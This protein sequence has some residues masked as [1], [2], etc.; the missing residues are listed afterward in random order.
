ME[1]GILVNVDKVVEQLYS[2]DGKSKE[3]IMNLLDIKRQD[4]NEII[5]R[6]NLQKPQVKLTPSNQKFVN[7]HREQIVSMLRKDISLKNIAKELNITSDK[8]WYLVR[9]TPDLA[10]ERDAQKERIHNAFIAREMNKSSLDYDNRS[11][12]G[13]E[14]KPILGYDTYYISNCGRVKHYVKA[15]DAYNVMSQ[16]KNVRTGR[17][18]VSLPDNNGKMHNLIVARLVAHAFCNGY[19]EKYNTV[20]H[21]DGDVTN[22]IAENLEWVSQGE[23]NKH[24]YDVLNRTRNVGHPLLYRINYQ[25]RYIFKTVAAFAR[26]I[27]KSEITARRWLE[28]PAKHDI[29]LL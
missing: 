15:Y 1:S 20:N 8:L 24:A 29:K 13:E 18:Y 7:A 5:R 16:Q 9:N 27:G 11:L 14:W 23:N 3:Y 19:S 17:L 28:E 10:A 6:L 12:V 2:K 22:N 26:F 21:I 25:N 4:L